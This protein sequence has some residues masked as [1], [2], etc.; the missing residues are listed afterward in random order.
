MKVKRI[1]V[2]FMRLSVE[3]LIVLARFVILKITGNAFFTTPDPALAD[4]TTATD[5][6]E[7][8]AAL[9]LEGGKTA[10]E[11][12]K[13]SR[14]KLVALLRSLA[15]YVEK[16]AKGSE[17]ILVS[18]GFELTKDPA[19][20]QRDAFWIV[21]GMNPGALLIGC[22]AY[23]NAVAYLWEES[24]DEK[25]PASDKDWSVVGTSAQRKTYLTG[26]TPD[27]KRWFRYRAL[28]RGGLMPGSD[29]ILF[30]IR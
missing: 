28:T 11:N 4:V 17:Q 12:L 26:F 1:K 24:V 27:A 16:I 10:R 23:P 9:A 22:K 7:T 14:A 30:T 21:P 20:S 19:V 13:V 8:K 2:G 25:P 5:D 29:P 6:L 3:F 18:S 15:W